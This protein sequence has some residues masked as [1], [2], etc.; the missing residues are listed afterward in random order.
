MLLNRSAAWRWRSARIDSGSDEVRASGVTFAR[1]SEPRGS[2]GN[3]SGGASGTTSDADDPEAAS[4]LLLARSATWAWLG[5][6]LCA[7]VGCTAFVLLRGPAADATWL[8]RFALVQ[9]VG[10]GSFAAVGLWLHN[11]S[12]TPSLARRVDIGLAAVTTLVLLASSW[13]VPRSVRPDLIAILAIGQM[14]VLRAAFVP[15]AP[16]RTL[17]VNVACTAPIVPFTYAYFAA[18]LPAGAES[19]PAGYA[20]YAAAFAASIVIVGN[21]VARAT[22]RLRERASQPPQLGQYSLVR[23]IGGGGMGVVYE[24][25]HTTLHRQTAIKVLR[26]EKAGQ[27]C[28]V[29]F[30]REARMTALLCHPNTVSVYDYGRTPGGT[31]YYAM[32]YIEGLDLDML[33]QHDGPQHPGRVIQI[34]SQ[35]CGSLAEAHEVGLVHQDIK[36]ANVFLCERAGMVDVVK[37]LDF[38]L[39]QRF[40]DGRAESAPLDPALRQQ[41][42]GT[43]HYIA[44]EAI[45]RTGEVDGRTDLYALGCVAHYLLTGLAPFSGNTVLEV[46]GQHLHA[47]PKSFAQQAKWPVSPELEQVV[48]SCLGKS[49]VHRPSDAAT[50][51][52]LLERC[53]EAKAWDQEHGRH[54]WAERGAA[55]RATVSA[56]RAAEA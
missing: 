51:R 14:L 29:R 55:L 27:E 22:E 19:G 53:P 2:G 5:T 23:K 54:W 39:V 4:T 42:L 7:L 20:A 12:A 18:R 15:S 17:L 36:P 44:P 52:A 31:F 47:T 50:L 37:V 43:P 26:P 34:L 16:L 38:G 46:L 32:E 24:A 6:S 41:F 1:A 9:L 40:E 28:L 21:L 13:H 3:G 11:A 45:L 49:R 48:L 10:A 56:S 33:V 8:A 30:E 35:I 25:K